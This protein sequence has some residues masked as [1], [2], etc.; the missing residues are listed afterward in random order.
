MI[1]KV[2]STRLD[3][4]ITYTN[5]SDNHML[6]LVIAVGYLSICHSP[7]AGDFNAKWVF[8]QTQFP[9]SKSDQMLK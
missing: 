8:F 4:N 1:L 7:Y 3:L 6:R 5:P 2:K 9:R